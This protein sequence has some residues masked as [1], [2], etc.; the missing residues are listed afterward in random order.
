M[1]KA[2][3]EW[4]VCDWFNV[5][6]EAAPPSLGALRGRVIALYAFA[7]RCRGCVERALPQAQE[8]AG[9]FAGAEV[10]VVGLHAVFEGHARS[11]LDALRTFIAERRLTFPIGVDA[12]DPAEPEGRPLT[13][14][15]YGMLGTP[16]VLLIDRAGHI[17]RQTLGPIGDVQIGA[18]IAT[19]LCEANN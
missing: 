9:V 11:G 12:H 1:R 10:S 17:R 18:D 14:A 5:T 3:A 15:A 19:L 4:V 16:T 2:A 8:V 7:M 6:P 13:M